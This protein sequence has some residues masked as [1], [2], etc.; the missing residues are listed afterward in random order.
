[1]ALIKIAMVD[2]QPVTLPHLAGIKKLTANAINGSNTV[3]NALQIVNE[4]WY[5]RYVSK[6]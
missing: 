2:T 4:S 1:M 6:Y 5:G 3:A